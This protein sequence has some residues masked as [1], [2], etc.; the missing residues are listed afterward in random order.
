MPDSAVI[1]A[2]APGRAGVIGNPTDGYGGA[3]I[4]SS[5]QERAWCELRAS[6]RW[7]LDVSGVTQEIL[8]EADLEL[9]GDYLDVA[10]AVLRFYWPAPPASI[11]SG[12]AIPI[13]AGLSGSTAILTSILGAILQHL[14][15]SLS[16]HEIAET[17]RVIEF[18]TLKV[19]CGFQDQYMI[20]FGGEH[21][22][23]FHGKEPGA[24]NP[25]PWAT[26]EP[27]PI[28]SAGCRLVLGHTGV[29]RLSGNV[30]KP[31]RQRWIE[32]EAAVVDGY[33]HI[34]T[35][36]QEGKKAILRG[37]WTLLGQLM[38]ENHAIQRDLG[39]SGDANERLIGAALEAGALGA[40]LAGAGA[41]GTI[42]ALC[43][44]PEPVRAS[45]HAVGA[46]KV[47]DVVPSEGLVVKTCRVP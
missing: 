2:S 8:S 47:W 34:A 41:G 30:H 5:I 32:R 26:M 44:D 1:R 37:D 15:V 3:V 25:L 20:A 14:G 7:F 43:T 36:A 22:M 16:R 46:E 38:N 12:T 45:L 27:V 23:D 19:T 18:N 42:I 6:E 24:P 21:Y 10:R 40:K 4:S 28:H 29:Q 11:R 31:L 9:R 13:K 35:L 33:R 39:G 17:A